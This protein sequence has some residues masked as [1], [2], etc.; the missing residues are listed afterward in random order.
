MTIPAETLAHLKDHYY[1]PANE[2]AR[3]R[4]SRVLGAA[5][6]RAGERILDLGCANGTFSWHTARLGARPVGLDL[7]MH[8]LSTGRAAVAALGGPA[9]PRI[10]GD[11]RRLPFRDNMFDVVI[12]ADFIEH[13]RDEDKAPIFAE[14]HRV[15]KPGGRGLVYTPNL[16]RVEWEIAGERLKRV[17]GLRREPVPRWQDYVDPDHFGLTYPRLTERRLEAA[18]FTTNLRYFEFHAPLLSRIPHLDRLLS[19]IAS[20]WFANRFL[21]TITK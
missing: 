21:I 15:M 1:E 12:N 10:S 5:A 6:V 17:L 20:A 19:P 13:T 14:M 4:V 2:W 18:G 8:A 3:Q 11:A 16:A 9:T 7:D